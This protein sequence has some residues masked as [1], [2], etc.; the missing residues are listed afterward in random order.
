MHSAIARWRRSPTSPIPCDRTRGG[1]ANRAGSHRLRTVPRHLQNGEEIR[2][3]IEA[4]L[5][6]G[7]LLFSA[8]WTDE[9][10]AGRPATTGAGAPLADPSRRLDGAR[11]F[12]RVSGPDANGCV[13]CHNRPAGAVGG[14]GDFVANTFEAA[15]RFDFITFDRL[16]RRKTSGSWTKRHA[17]CRSPQSEMR[18]RR[19]A[20]TA[21][22]TSRCWRGRSPP[23]SA[24][25]ATPLLPGNRNGSSP[26][27][28]LLEYWRGAPMA[29]GSRQA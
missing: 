4:L 16:D 26:G 21:P 24:A 12:N 13:G 10:G 2:L 19:Q 7:R 18:D 29:V 27:A 25:S 3:P 15:Q 22:A 23:I 5:E 20:S 17:A 11:A 28:F 8:N 1:D 9:D 6:Q 14:A